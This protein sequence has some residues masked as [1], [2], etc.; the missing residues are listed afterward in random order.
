MTTTARCLP[1]S[2]FLTICMIWASMAHA[3]NE[4]IHFYLDADLTNASTSS[5]SIEQGILTALSEVDNKIVGRR[6]VLLKR[7]HHGNSR[8]SLDNLK[9]FL[10][11]DQALALFAG[12]HSPPLLANRTFINEQGILLLDPWAAAGPITRYANGKNWIFRLS[13]DDSKAGSVLVNHLI[14]V[15]GLKKP[16]LLLEQTGW[17]R[18]N[19]KT[20]GR[21]LAEN[22]L[23]PTGIFWFNWGLK[24]SSARILLRQIAGTGADSILFVGN[25][26]E[27]K[28]FARA[29][30]ELS[31]S[32]KMPIV[33]H[34]GITGGDFPQVIGLALREKI[35]LTFLQTSFSFVSMPDNL[36]GRQVLKQ[37]STV[38][39]DLINKAT[40]IKAPAGFVHGYDLTKILIAAVLQAGL[41]G[42]IIED[43]ENVRN[44]L[45]ELK[46][47]VKGLIKI[48]NKP[49]GKFDLEHPDSHEALSVEDFTMAR[50][51]ENDEIL[52]L[53]VGE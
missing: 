44:A 8:R 32:K 37:A 42:D 19:K 31:G 38:F 47:P 1:G 7:D 6:V 53:N 18:S 27:G 14:N 13:V 4:P 48:Y 12:L 11:D 33:S 22:D 16:A 28:I 49:F 52:L 20:M 5:L 35:D 15:R 51:G 43:R 23:A 25:S 40:D 9:Q 3:Q 50:Y 21:A 41:S 46:T 17:G 39:P 26:P 36:F 29:M 34:W 30:A 2:I 10:A 24:E 45:E